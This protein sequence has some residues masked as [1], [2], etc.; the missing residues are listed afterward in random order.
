MNLD[1]RIR[2]I[3]LL[4]S[5]ARHFEVKPSSEDTLITCKS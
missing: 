2:K 4:A 5:A 1:S 3:T